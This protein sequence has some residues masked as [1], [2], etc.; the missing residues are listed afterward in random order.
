M[1]KRRV[2]DDEA[3]Q[4][5]KSERP[6]GRYADPFWVTYN[7]LRDLQPALRLDPERTGSL[8]DWQQTVRAKLR[9]LLAFPED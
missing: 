9:D 4:V 5:F 2:D 3:V 8:A 6:D 1:F 7:Q